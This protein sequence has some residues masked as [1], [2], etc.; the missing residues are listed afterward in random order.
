[1]ELYTYDI[2]NLYTWWD[3]PIKM[4]THLDSNFNWSMNISQLYL[5]K[6]HQ[7]LSTLDHLY[8][9]LQLTSWINYLDLELIKFCKPD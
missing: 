2:N 1:M 7:V 5:G 3:F 4:K 8:T 9:F 6:M